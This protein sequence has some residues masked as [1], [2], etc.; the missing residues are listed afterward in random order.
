MHY[1]CHNVFSSKS[2]ALSG[3]SEPVKCIEIGLHVSVSAPTVHLLLWLLTG[4]PAAGKCMHAVRWTAVLILSP[5][6]GTGIKQCK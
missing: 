4:E 2:I 1:A 5:G 6:E 3:W